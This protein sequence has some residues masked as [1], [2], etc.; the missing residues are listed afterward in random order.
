MGIVDSLGSREELIGILDVLGLV[1]LDTRAC[2]DD[3]DGALGI[4]LC[5]VLS[6]A[7]GYLLLLSLDNFIVVHDIG[8]QID[9][10]VTLEDD[11]DAEVGHESAELLAHSLDILVVIVRAV[12]IERLVEND[13]LP[14]S[15]ACLGVRLEPCEL[16][17]AERLILAEVVGV[18][19]DEVS[20]VVIIGIEH[21]A[22]S[23]LIDCLGQGKVLVEH[24]SALLVVARCGHDS[25]A[26]DVFGGI[27]EPLPLFEVL[28]VIDLVARA[29]KELA[30]GE[31][32]ERGIDYLAPCTVLNSVLRLLVADMEEGEGIGIVRSLDYTRTA[33]PAVLCIADSV[34]ILRAGLETGYGRGVAV[35]IDAVGDEA[36]N[37]E[38]DAGILSLDKLGGRADLDSLG[39]LIGESRVFRILGYL[40][41]GIFE[42]VLCIPVDASLGRC[43]AG[44][45]CAYI[46]GQ[47][48]IVLSDLGL[49]GTV[50]DESHIEVGLLG[51]I[52]ILNEAAKH[53][54]DSVADAVILALSH[55]LI[56][57][58]GVEYIAQAAVLLGQEVEHA[59]N[60][61][62]IARVAAEDYIHEDVG[63]NAYGA[64]DRA[65]GEELAGV[66]LEGREDL[67]LDDIVEQSVDKEVDE[68]LCAVSVL[69][70]IKD[71]VHELV[72]ADILVGVVKSVKNGVSGI[73]K[74]ALLVL[75]LHAHSLI[76]LCA[77]II[78]DLIVESLCDYAVNDLHDVVGV[79]DI[80][81]VDL[82]AQILDEAHN[83]AADRK[84]LDAADLEAVR[85]ERI[86]DYLFKVDSRSLE[87]CIESAGLL[88]VLE[89]A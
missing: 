65:G 73:L 61:I 18:E 32:F 4:E 88:N 83:V 1:V 22:L 44:E 70:V 41:V 9:M 25:G 10:I 23:V 47:T 80:S 63:H 14:L 89:D 7:E 66:E 27:E 39:K 48:H 20:V 38:I 69:E 51:R 16:I 45:S 24:I 77:F 62:L 82:R 75:A 81:L 53:S 13:Y 29:G 43:V 11:V 72:V 87:I 12:G 35:D 30:L 19:D 68:L 21:A 57:N 84:Y 54:A 28:G 74:G 56:H 86:D 59:V 5:G 78:R 79:I 46:R 3:I 2:A 58:D 40:N 31:E 64:G 49:D 33:P 15:V 17:V 52:R 85:A 76:E 26:L 50:I 60:N 37:A 36:D 8:A 55:I 67:T 71:I 42:A 34:A 6:A